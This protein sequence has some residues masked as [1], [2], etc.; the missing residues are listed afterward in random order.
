MPKAIITGATGY[1]GSHV[2]RE[3]LRNG[4]KVSI[5]SQ[6]EFGYD[7][8]SD[9]KDKLEIFEYSGCIADL[10]Q[11]FRYSDADVVMHLAAAVITN[12]TSEQVSVLINSNIA[13]GTQI[14]EAMKQSSVNLFVGTGSYWQNFNSDDYNPVDLYAA[15]KEAFEKI[16]QYYVDACGIRAITLRLYDVYGED[17]RR[18]KLWTLLRDIAG[19]GR[20][21]DISAGDQYLDM[22]HVQ[23]VAKAFIAAYNRLVYHCVAKNEVYAVRSG[24]LMK[25]KDIVGKFQNIIG[26]EILLNWGGR[27][28]K[29]RE[30]MSPNETIPLI[31][32]WQAEVSLEEGFARFI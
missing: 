28:Y 15:T 9:I 27:P 16:L 1:I 13:F 20:V 17:D 3:L 32:D 18:P 21:L 25:L 19:T 29:S 10:I 7:N 12:Y 8:I 22:I 5:I 14:L 11:F 2:V 24:H 31:P 26:K 6:P 4:W 30:V 23:D